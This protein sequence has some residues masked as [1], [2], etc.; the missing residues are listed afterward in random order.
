MNRTAF[1]IAS[2]AAMVAMT[3]A[4][5]TSPSA[6][7][8]GL[9]PVR[10]HA[11]TDRQAAQL[12]DQASRA[13]QQ[14]QLAQAV[15]LLEQ[16]VALSPRDAGYRLLLADAYLKSGRFDSARATF[17]DV[18]ELDPSNVRASLSLALIQIGQGRPAAA[19][20]ILDAIADRAPAGD[21]GL[22]Y[23]LAG[24]SERAVQVL[25]SAARS[26]M[27]T[28]RTRQNLA[29]AYAFAGEWRRARAIAA[30][31]ISPADIDARMA[32]WAV[33]ARPGAGADQIA[34]LLGVRPGA[35]S[36]QPGALAL[37][38]S[39][40]APAAVV[41]EVAPMPATVAAPVPSR[42][43]F[44]PARS[45]APEPVELA[46]ADER[47]A[48]APAFWVSPETYQEE[49]IAEAVA[50]EPVRAAPT[51][52]RV[53][54]A[55]AASRVA[56][57]V[58]APEAVEV[59]YDMPAFSSEEGPAPQAPD[60]PAFEAPARPAAA[61]R[62]VAPVAAARAPAVPRRAAYIRAAATAPLPRPII[63]RRR[64]VRSG[65]SPVVVQ[66]GAFSSEANAE[67]AW[68][69][70]SRRHGIS[71]RRP[72]TTTFNHNGRTF[73]RVSVSG[74]ASAADAQR[75]CGQ[76]RGSGGVCFVRGTAGDASI[77]WAARYSNP[78]QREV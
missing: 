3:V 61:S 38:S 37:A 48:E 62:R 24:Q 53:R 76:I 45:R 11:R 54:V 20:A 57:P 7:T 30:Q 29:L 65:N 13:L 68:V 33:L 10:A 5:V 21:I 43:Q 44:A 69:S 28:P 35:D 70:L 14:G 16:A 12:H 66:I 77:R 42:A 40:A 49:A 36:G 22:A 18:I 47:P 58:P 63:E 2:S 75:L 55:G 32:Q 71:G 27:A 72:L 26:P 25:E 9:E 4:G 46:A 52:R 59:R 56:E 60:Q 8:R 67:R 39:G 15:T 78:R 17:A 31:D 1:K 34:S 50:P 23:A 41:A 74:F 6:A 19:V 64:A 73:H 51:P